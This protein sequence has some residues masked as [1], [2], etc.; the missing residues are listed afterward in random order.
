MVKGIDFNMSSLAFLKCVMLFVD[1]IVIGSV[2]TRKPAHSGLRLVENFINK[3]KR[4]GNS[5][6]SRPS[7]R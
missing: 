4:V 6:K 1:G 3:A 2:R 5:F 7:T